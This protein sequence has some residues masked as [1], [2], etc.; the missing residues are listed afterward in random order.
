MTCGDR[1]I[2]TP[3]DFE[4]DD[5][6]GESEGLK[7]PRTYTNGS[8]VEIE[9][10]PIDGKKDSR[11]LSERDFLDIKEETGSQTSLDDIFRSESI[12]STIIQAV[13]ERQFNIDA[14]ACT[15]VPLLNCVRLLC[16]FL[17]SGE[18]GKVLPDSSTRVSVK[19]LALH[20]IGSAL[21]LYPEALLA[22]VMPDELQIEGA[23][24]QL[25]RD[26]F[27]LQNHEDP[28]IKGSVSAVIGH[29]V[30]SAMKYSL[31]KFDQWNM[32]CLLY[33]SPSPRDRG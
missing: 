15:G 3:K 29:F 9:G 24:K 1:E 26:V 30:K 22:K 16:S 14:V 31:G 17:L 10:D 18:P 32:D 23:S 13:I 5:Q 28:Q 27:V 4:D 20:C 25:V 7:L 6:E 2:D 33:T 21:N 8:M 19:S 12:S 11:S